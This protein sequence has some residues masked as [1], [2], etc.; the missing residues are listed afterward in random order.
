MDNLY[1]SKMSKCDIRQIEE[2]EKLSFSKSWSYN[3]IYEELSN[4]NAHFYVAKDNNNIVLG[5]IGMHGICGEGYITNLAVHPKYRRRGIANK[6]LSNLIKYAKYN[7]YDFVTLEVRKSNALAIHVYKENGF[8][9]IGI[10]RN[11]YS[12]PNEDAIIMTYYF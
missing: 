1:I 10:R 3:S 4:V 8:V 6:L 12:S 7:K 11:F 5:Y 2:I 9:E